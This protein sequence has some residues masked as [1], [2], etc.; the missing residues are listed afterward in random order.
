ML[1]QQRLQDVMVLS[2]KFNTV[3]QPRLT[4]P[5]NCYCGSSDHFGLIG[6]VADLCSP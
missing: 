6:S 4:R 1:N 2:Q 3:L 5:T